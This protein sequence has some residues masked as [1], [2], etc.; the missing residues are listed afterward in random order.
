MI[1]LG[2]VLEILN[3]FSQVS[4]R[5]KSVTESILVLS[6]IKIDGLRWAIL[7]LT[8]RNITFITHFL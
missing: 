5:L 2:N 8:R 6:F 7:L 1:Q 3:M 4:C